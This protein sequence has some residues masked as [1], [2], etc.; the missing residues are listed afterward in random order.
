MAR[1]CAAI[2]ASEA[3]PRSGLAYAA[4]FAALCYLF[5]P[6]AD[7]LAVQ[8]LGTVGA[9]VGMLWSAAAPVA[10]M[11]GLAAARDIDRAPWKVGRAQAILGYLI[12]L[13]GTLRLVYDLLHEL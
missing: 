8:W 2:F 10:M 11:C 4:G 9:G 13:P 1:A 3:R 5:R 6:S 12:G 7:A